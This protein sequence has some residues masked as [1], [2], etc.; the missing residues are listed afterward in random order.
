MKTKEEELNDLTEEIDI[1]S[2]SEDI[3]GCKTIK[4][5][6]YGE[7]VCLLKKTKQQTLKDVL[8]IIDKTK[9]PEDKDYRYS[10]KYIDAWIF[11]LKD[12]IKKLGDT[13]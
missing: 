7:V 2:L 5:I 3:R 12:Q 4:V 6:R 13:S 1:R 9:L 11:E 8:N 10:N